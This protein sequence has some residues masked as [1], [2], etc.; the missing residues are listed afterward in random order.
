MINERIDD[1]MTET[2]HLVGGE[3]EAVQIGVHPDSLWPKE[4]VG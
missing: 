4:P 2:A 3:L 1:G